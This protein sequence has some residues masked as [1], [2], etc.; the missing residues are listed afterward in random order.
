MEDPTPLKQALPKLRTQILKLAKRLAFIE[1]NLFTQIF[2]LDEH[3]TRLKTFL[4]RADIEPDM[5]REAELFH[6]NLP[7]PDHGP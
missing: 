2:R 1:S 3:I 5:Q 7:A 6:Q 4:E